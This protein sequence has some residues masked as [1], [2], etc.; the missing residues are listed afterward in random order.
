M[1]DG[2]IHLWRQSIDSRVFKNPD[3]WKVWTWCLMKA[4]YK[5]R[6]VE[7]KT[8]KSKIEVHLQPGQ[9]VFG[10]K[11]A[12][13]EL[14]MPESSVRNRMKKLK[15]M[16]NVDIKEDRQYSTISIVNWEGY[17]ECEEKEDRQEDRQRTGKGQAKDTNKKG[18]KDKKGK[19]ENTYSAEFQKLWSAY[20]KKT[21][22]KKAWQRWNN[23][24]GLR[25]G[26]ETL[27]SAIE[28]QKISRSWKEGFVPHLST[29][30][31][32]A[33]WEDEVE[34]VKDDI[35]QWDRIK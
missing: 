12:A 26:I 2:F 24:N 34:A 25:P 17:Q 31:N 28:R 13:K 27:L 7:M 32:G 33:R 15:N 5:E 18:N 3:L 21:D 29:W 4:T 20:P 30:L 16:R 23:M 6:W 35:M 22:K 19:K 8:G 1:S 14:G 9:F 10:R 11:S